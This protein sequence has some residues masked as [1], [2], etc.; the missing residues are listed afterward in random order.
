AALAPLRRGL[1]AGDVAGAVGWLASP[2]SGAV[3]GQ[4]IEVDAGWGVL[5]LS[6]SPGPR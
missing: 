4:V 1:T 5:G 6:G 3:T 2:A